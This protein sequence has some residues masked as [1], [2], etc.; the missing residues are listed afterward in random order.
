MLRPFLELLVVAFDYRQIIKPINHIILMLAN[1]THNIA[2]AHVTD[3]FIAL[4]H[5]WNT[6]DAMGNELLDDRAYLISFFYFVHLAVHD[7]MRL[8][9][10]FPLM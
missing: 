10:S 7:L 5:D 2:V 1:V 4:I 3:N 8:H 9:V 6:A